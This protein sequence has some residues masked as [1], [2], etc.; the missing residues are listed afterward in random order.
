MGTPIPS[1]SDIPTKVDDIKISITEKEKVESSQ[2]LSPSASSSI[3]GLI[4]NLKPRNQTEVERNSIITEIS[5]TLRKESIY[6]Y[7]YYYL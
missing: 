7:N 2:L 5:V 3:S 4:R 1:S 6:I